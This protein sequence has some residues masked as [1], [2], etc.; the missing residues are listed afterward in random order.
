[1]IKNNLAIVVFLFTL[2]PLISADWPM[3]RYDTRHTAASPDNL[4][5]ELHLQW[6]RELGKPA[7]A[8]PANQKKL[9]FD[10][11]YEPVADAKAIYVPSM[12]A[13]KVS[14]YD[15]STGKELWSFYA[16]APVRFAPVIYKDKLYFG[17]D[18]G[19]LYCLNKS[20][21]KLVFKKMLAPKKQKQLGNERM[22]SL[23]PVRGAPVLHDDKI[24]VS[25]GIWPFMG[26]FIYCINADTGKTIWCNSGSGSIYIQQQ[27]NSPA[28]AGVAPQ[29]YM[30]VVGD[31]L[32]V[33]GG[34]TVP[35][36]YDLKT[37]EFLYFHLASRQF[38][39]AAGGYAISAKMPYFFNG[40][41]MYQVKDGK[42]VC[43]NPVSVIDK[44]QLLDISGSDSIN[45]CFLFSKKLSSEKREVKDY[46]GKM[47]EKSFMVENW[48]SKLPGNSGK[49]FMQAG[50][51]LYC[52]N[53]EGKLSAFSLQKSPQKTATPIWTSNIKGTPWS[54][55][56][57][58]GKLYV[59]TKQGTLYCFGDKKTKSLNYPEPKNTLPAASGSFASTGKRIIELQQDKAGYCLVLGINSEAW[60][61]ELLAKS[62]M[63]IIVIEKDQNK[64]RE[65]RKKMNSAGVY[66]NRV[67]AFKC[68][69]KNLPPYFASLVVSEKMP[70]NIKGSCEGI[71]RILRPYGG[72]VYFQGNSAKQNEF[73]KTVT[74]MKLPGAV[75]K[76]WNDGLMR[77]ERTGSLPGSAS[78][79]HQYADAGNSVISKDKLVKLPL[80]ILWFGGASNE[81]ILPRHGHGP[82]PEISGGRVIIEGM[83]MLRAL[84]VYT[85]RMLWE[86]D[87]KGLGK[88]Y[89]NTSHHPGANQI[90]SNYVS[91]PDGIYAITPK[92]CQMLDPTTGKKIKTFSVQSDNSGKQNWG[93]IAVDDKYLVAATSPLG[94]K[95]GKAPKGQT[96]KPSVNFS[97]KST[98]VIP[99]NADWHYL[100]GKAE[101]GWQNPGFK[102]S[103]KWKKGQAGFGYGDNDDKTIFKDMRGKEK[104]LLIRK[105]F[106]VKDA[107]TIGSLA[108][109]IRY[110]DG[111][112]AYLN[113]KEIARSKVNV[114]G[115]KIK[116]I[117]HEAEKFES[118]DVTN[119]KKLLKTKGNVLAIEGHNVSA[120]SS[121]FSLDP[122]LVAYA[123]GK[124]EEKAATK[125][126]A[127][128]DESILDIE[129]VQVNADYASA[130]RHITVFNRYSGKKLW[131]KPAN[132]SFRHNA[133]IAGNG[134]LFCIDSLSD[135]K[136]AFLKR[137][138]FKSQAPSVLYALDL[139]TGKELWKTEKN[140]FGTWLG[141]SADNDILIQAGSAFRDRA[142]DETKKG[143][144]A[145]NATTGK[146][147][148]ENDDKYYGPC[149][150]HRNKVLTQ[151]SGYDMKTGKKATMTNPLSKEAIPWKFRRNYGCNTTIGSEHLLTF[152]SA[153]AGYFDL[154]T[155]SGTGNLGGF[156]SGC[157]S[158]LIAA[159]GV[160]NAPDY[161]RTCT[162]SYQNQSSLALSHF[163][164]V[165]TWT[166]TDVPFGSVKR[167]GINF[168][169]PGDRFHNDSLWLEFPYAGSPSP[170]LPI[171]IIPAK[172]Q[173]FRKHST[174]VKGD[175]LNWVAASGIKGV[176]K[177]KLSLPDMSS[178]DIRICF[179]EPENLKAGDRVFSVLANGKTLIENLDVI[180]E[181][182]KSDKALIKEFKAIPIT[183]GK[184]EI[185]LKAGKGKSIISGIEIIGDK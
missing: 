35:A 87:I 73:E 119:F 142:R 44:E 77:L 97:G 81:K 11:S 61:N 118:F 76:I 84:D 60:I 17:S 154:N 161:T 70:A 45:D 51:T 125:P 131:S 176:D 162:C 150:L 80:G 117:N 82:N 40:G 26:T 49:L 55:I 43:R 169:A 172:P 12:S 13:D 41:N 48:R 129:G 57:A 47:V 31:K 71:Y 8:W 78:W 91:M 132:F 96:T 146:L 62:E 173:T 156:K 164:E 158:N 39:K 159:D 144:A 149:L 20:S 148:W 115:D 23:W 53:A 136:F 140:V 74:G 114:T 178:C 103:T 38:G 134:K 65:F 104:V 122:Y 102:M 155:T 88:F 86:A 153:A 93:Y 160:L 101:T 174:L 32:L 121:D 15:S 170:K 14:A 137:R 98:P 168:G 94:I 171:A 56:T 28:F 67:T 112:I 130:S 59:V 89:D 109:M 124:T 50:R 165:E 147:L 90:G 145:Y 177:I 1:M 18:D 63:Q 126:V 127:E 180:K 33:P 85:G 27:H 120:R 166:F 182:G 24:Y 185:S 3:W 42:G 75:T 128:A 52:G 46:K 184:L 66:G 99:Q 181:A 69:L 19:N 107:A 64:L 9:R 167:L 106:D 2:L 139:K 68:S 54:M 183:D 175:D 16:D 25:A 143:L 138:G 157:S 133:I 58:G 116:A 72:A 100:M 37:G 36:A 22:I 135:E 141:Y 95:L 179:S 163:P 152:R 110:D 79:T 6:S 5:A 105:S 123:A 113:G 21:G 30:T 92:K 4:P 111:F 83:D 108:L 151:W 10:D 34:R 29:G 7:S